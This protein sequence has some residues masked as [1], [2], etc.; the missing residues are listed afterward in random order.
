LSEVDITARLFPYSINVGPSTAGCDSAAWEITGISWRTA[1]SASCNCP[2]WHHFIA[3]WLKNASDEIMIQL[4][5]IEYK[6][7]GFRRA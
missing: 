3:H 2:D 1:A 4:M 6:D 5:V 7:G